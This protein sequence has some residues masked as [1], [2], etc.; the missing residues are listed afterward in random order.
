MEISEDRIQ[1]Y[2]LQNYRMFTI[3]YLLGTRPTF[4]D[5]SEYLIL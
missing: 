5:E 2:I 4:V 1:N 3:E